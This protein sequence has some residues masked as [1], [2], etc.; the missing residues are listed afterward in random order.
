MCVKT[1]TVTGSFKRTSLWREL[2]K[3]ENVRP[4]NAEENIMPIAAPHCEESGT[5]GYQR[6]LQ[7]LVRP[8]PH[9]PTF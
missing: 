9:R 1:V 2:I 8:E 6:G 7:R 3:L 4:L 5:S